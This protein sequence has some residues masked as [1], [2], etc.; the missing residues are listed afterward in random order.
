MSL[1]CTKKM[2]KDDMAGTKRDDGGMPIPAEN[3]MGYRGSQERT[4]RG[5]WE[6]AKRKEERGGTVSK[7]ENTEMART[8]TGGWKLH[9]D[10]EVLWKGRREM[11]RQFVERV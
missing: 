8:L 7:I 1:L 11:F 3:E 2:G 10:I 4:R 9:D 6:E 5:R